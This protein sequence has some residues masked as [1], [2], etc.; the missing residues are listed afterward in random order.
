MRQFVSSFTALKNQLE[1]TRAWAHLVELQVNANTTAYFTTSPETLT[2]NGNTYMPVPMMIGEYEQSAGNELPQLTI[3][4]FNYRG[5]AF[6]FAKDNDLTLNNV[7]V[8]LVN[9]SLTN[10]GAEDFVTLQILG[11]VFAGEV[12]RF[13]LG[14]NFNYDA[15]GP[16]R[17]WNR[18]QFPS[19]PYGMRHFA[20]V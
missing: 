18:N 16:R 14:Y 7:T 2:H 17:T 10:S 4:V 3:D 13:M 15:Q 5:M 12:G 20:I 19:I 9:V 8:R 6:Q 1:G 11:S